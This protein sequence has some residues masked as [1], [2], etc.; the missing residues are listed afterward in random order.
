V[1]SSESV[2]QD[3]LFYD[4]L[5]DKE[6][7]LFRLELTVPKSRQYFRC[8]LSGWQKSQISVS[9]AGCNSAQMCK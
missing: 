3:K 5:E 6:T 4:S 7:M 9:I 1:L 2:F 8:Y